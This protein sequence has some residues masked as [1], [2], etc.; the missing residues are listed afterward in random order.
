MKGE[1]MLKIAQEFK[2]EVLITE[3]ILRE[4]VYLVGI[5]NPLHLDKK[6][7]QEIGLKERVVPGILLISLVESSFP[8]N[9]LT[10][11]LP[12]LRRLK[13]IIFSSPVYV[14]QKVEIRA[15]VR[16]IISSRLGLR[17]EIEIR[18]FNQDEQKLAL[19][20]KIELLIKEGK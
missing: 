11:D 12:I 20:G 14:G 7:A 4:F 19:R 13:E 16:D 15:K 2:K 10:E 6:L 9:L 3:K 5:S 17:V 1:K 18:I 8:R